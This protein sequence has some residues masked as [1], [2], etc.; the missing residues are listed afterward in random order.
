MKLLMQYKMLFFSSNNATS[1]LIDLLTGTTSGPCIE[2]ELWAD[3]K[4]QEV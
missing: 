2:G 4:F 3:W 1:F